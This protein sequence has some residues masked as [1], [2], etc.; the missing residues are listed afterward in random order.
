M[1]RTTF[2]VRIAFAPRHIWVLA[3]IHTTIC[4]HN[5]TTHCTHAQKC[6]V[7]LGRKG[8]LSSLK[9]AIHAAPILMSPVVDQ[10][11]FV[12][13]D[14]SDY[15]VGA[16]LEQIDPHTRTR[17]PVTYFSHLLNPAE[18]KY[19]THERELLQ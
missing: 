18:C 1:A 16:S 8:A 5:T 2:F 3:T 11:F 6:R 10:P 15:A 9:R 17:R 7:A 12:V 14:A 19:P 13:T 4:W